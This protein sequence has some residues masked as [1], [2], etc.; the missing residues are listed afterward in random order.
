MHTA[1]LDTLLECMYPLEWTWNPW[2][3]RQ[4]EGSKIHQKWCILEW[5]TLPIENGVCSGTPKT[6]K[7]CQNRCILESGRMG[8]SY[9]E[10]DFYTIFLYMVFEDSTILM[11]LGEV[12]KA[13]STT[14]AFW[15]GLTVMNWPKPNFPK[16]FDLITTVEAFDMYNNLRD[17]IFRHYK[18]ELDCLFQQP[19]LLIISTGCTHVACKLGK[20]I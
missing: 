12:T 14:M 9:V 3:H 8:L 5:C 17:A 7:I 13:G 16:S 20:V 18:E 1:V 11:R 4:A 15:F 19:I 10:K 6:S 2:A